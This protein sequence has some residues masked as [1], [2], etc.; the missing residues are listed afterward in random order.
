MRFTPS[1]LL[2]VAAA[3]TVRAQVQTEETQSAIEGAPPAPSPADPL[4]RPPLDP[5]AECKPYGFQPVANAIPSFPKIAANVTAILPNDA[6]AKAKFASFSAQIPNIAPRGTF[7]GDITGVQYDRAADPDC[8][9]T[10][11]QC[12]KPKLAGLKPDIVIVPEPRALG[13][14][15]D[16]GPFCGHNR[17]YNYLESKNQKAT[18][19][20]IGT[21][22][23]NFPLEAQRAVADGHEICVHTWSHASLVAATNEGAF[24]EL[25]YT[26]Q[27]IKLVTGV[28][29]TCWRP[30]KGDVDDRIRFIAQSLGLDT[31][32]WGFDTF[33]WEVG[34]NSVTPQSV[35]G[36]YDTLVTKAGS[37][38]FN[39][40]GA[41]LLMHELNNYTMQVAIDNYPKLASAFDHILPVGVAYNKTT[42]YAETT[43]KQ[44]SFS[45]CACFFLAFSLPSALLPFFHCLSHLLPLA[46]LLCS[47]SAPSLSLYSSPP[48]MPPVLSAAGWLV[49]GHDLL[50][51]WLLITLCPLLSHLPRPYPVPSSICRY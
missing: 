1:T 19:F 39:S 12:V 42:P 44:Q 15:F 50:S 10:S 21:N 11:T 22:V 33:D 49:R 20:Y 9:W 29:P 14:G 45:E 43:I 5:E 38:A 27:A 3:A 41:I 36:N 40:Q 30:P 46:G 28:T 13:Y 25:W 35:Q 32:M 48:A 2:L 7:S 24:A 16:D 47:L 18:M 37:G 31:I 17:F 51:S 4:T 34:M 8:W 23:M 6:A 26:M